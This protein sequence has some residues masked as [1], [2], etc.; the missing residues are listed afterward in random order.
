M[1]QENKKIPTGLFFGS[2]NPVHTGHLIIA[3]YFLQNTDLQQVWFVLSPQNPLK[4]DKDLL[5]ERERLELLKT[6]ISDNPAFYLC[7][8]ELG[9]ERPSYTVKTLSELNKRFPEREFFLIIGSDNLEDLKR[10]KDYKK[11]LEE[12]DIYVYKRSEKIN[13]PYA[14]HPN[15]KLFDSPLLNI[16]SSM[17]R[18]V[19]AG[20]RKPRYLVP[21]GVLELIGEK[22]FYSK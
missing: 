10:W 17:I 13:S 3:D 18:D 20:G 2:F 15:V 9:M 6:A 12:T 5:G 14:S 11:L 4:T 8:I 1:N 19:I 21:D 7:D 22:G 16:S